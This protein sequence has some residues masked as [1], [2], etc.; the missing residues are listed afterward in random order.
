MIATDAATGMI[1]NAVNHSGL[2]STNASN[3]K[4][5]NPTAMCAVAEILM[6]TGTEGAGADAELTPPSCHRLDRR[7]RGPGGAGRNLTFELEGGY[8]Q[9]LCRPSRFS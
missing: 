9:R 2:A 4:V 6:T 8:R 3:P 7:L 5:K 1:N